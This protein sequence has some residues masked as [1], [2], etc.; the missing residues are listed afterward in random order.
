[1]IVLEKCFIEAVKK[2]GN[3][4]N[5]VLCEIKNKFFQISSFCGIKKNYYWMFKEVDKLV[6]FLQAWLLLMEKN[7]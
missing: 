1:M 2:F 3:V 4:G 7:G 6:D 5:L